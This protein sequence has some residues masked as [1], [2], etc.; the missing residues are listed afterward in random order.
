MDFAN[1]ILM[2]DLDGT[3]LTDDKKILGK[4]MAAINRFRAGGGLFTV[5]TGRSYAM[6]KRAGEELGLDIP[7]VLFN[8]AAVFDFKTDKFLWRCEIDNKAYDYVRIIGEQFPKIGAEVLC[9]QSVI[10]PYLNDT[11]QMHLDW[12]QVDAEFRDVSDL[13]KSG[14]LKFLFADE[15]EKLDVVEEF[16]R[17]GD[18]GG[19]HWIRSAPLF[20]ECL[21]K[22][23]DKSRGFAE[24]IRILGAEKRFT[25]AV[26]DYMNDI[27]MIQKAQLGIAVGSAH[28]SVKAAAD[29]IVCDNNSGAISEVI[30]YI[31]RL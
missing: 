12:E 16:V 17:N 10:V 19:V 2:T 28:E 27:A 6:A 3:L 23:V 14:W 8:G 15:P 29:L 1:V 11:E 7:A 31:E 21:P 24:L 26:G 22:D 5:A 4:D 30:D 13:P 18:F 20:L 25:V 9:E